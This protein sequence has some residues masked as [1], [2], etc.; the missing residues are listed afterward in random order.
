M[1]ENE[2]HFDEKPSKLARNEACGLP[3]TA[4]MGGR[5]IVA[6]KVGSGSNVLS[7]ELGA[8]INKK[9]KEIVES[10]SKCATY[11]GLRKQLGESDDSKTGE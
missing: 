2:Y 6:G 8:K 4:G 5:K 9:R 1:K 3:R 10:V 7:Q 11:E